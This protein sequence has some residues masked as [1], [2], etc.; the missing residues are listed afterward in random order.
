MENMIMSNHHHLSPEERELIMID[1]T[2]CYHSDTDS[3][4]ME[5]FG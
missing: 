4:I 1:N 2:K 3:I 5:A